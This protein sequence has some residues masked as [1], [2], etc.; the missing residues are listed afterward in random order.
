MNVTFHD[1]RITGILTVVPKHVAYF[2]DEIANYDFPERSSLKLQKLLGLESHRYLVDD[3]ITGSDMALHGIRH[4]S[5]PGIL[6]P[7][8]TL[9]DAH[10]CNSDSGS[11]CSGN[12]QHYSRQSRAQT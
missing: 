12:Q 8:R 4:W 1:K 3:S 2:A 6:P 5:E 11:L 9:P 10:L 7:L